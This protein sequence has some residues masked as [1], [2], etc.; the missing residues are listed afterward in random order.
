MIYHEVEG[1][2]PKNIQCPLCGEEVSWEDKNAAEYACLY[3]CVKLIPYPHHLLS[4]HKEYLDEASRIAKPIF[5]SASAF[6]LMFI[7]SALLIK[8]STITV[9]FGVC[10]V[11]L[12]SLGTYFRRRLIA[13]FRIK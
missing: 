3:A 4:K 12:W 9:M 13:K 10:T 8:L 6:T 11:A 5:Y 7:I 2:A 1:N